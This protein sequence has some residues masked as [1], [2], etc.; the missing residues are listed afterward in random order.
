MAHVLF[1]NYSGTQDLHVTLLGDL[2]A[3][4]FGQGINYKLSKNW[5]QKC[6]DYNVDALQ[7]WTACNFVILIELKA[8][9]GMTEIKRDVIEISE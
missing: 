7:L 6:N 9:H 2:E 3:I 5:H 4:K 1:G 8:E